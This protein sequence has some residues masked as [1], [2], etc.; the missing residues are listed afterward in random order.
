M[1]RVPTAFLAIVLVAVG[2]AGC[3]SPSRGDAIAR[4]EG[5]YSFWPPPPNDPRI[6]FLASFRLSSDVE[7]PRGVID[8]LVF[9]DDTEPLPIG[10]P[11]GVAMW[12]GRIY[13]CDIT[14]PAVV[15]LDLRERETRL[16]VARGVER[17]V[18]PTDIAIA[19]DGMK[20]VVDRRLGRVFV[21]DAQDRHVTTFG[22]D[23]L[24][25]T[26]I[27]VRGEELLVPDMATKQVLVMNRRDGE[28][29][30]HIGGPDAESGSLVCPLGVEPAPGGSLFVTD[31]IRGVAVRY[32]PEGNLELELGGI[33]DAPGHFTRPKHIA[34][35]RDGILYVVDAAFQNVQL[36]DG[37]GQVLMFFGGAGEFGG[38]MSLPAGVAIS[39]DDLDLFA[40]LVHPDFEAQRLVIVTNQFGRNKVS[41]YAL[42]RLREGATLDDMPMA[43][44]TQ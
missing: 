34:V 42:G 1:N 17:M 21:F 38:S 28:R 20:Y 8:R 19:D 3:A 41:V 11:Y 44:S 29:I 12:K 10:K 33:G 22:E 26:G 37:E 2:A 18:Q 15:I 39:E 35:D 7:A 14:N 43:P 5:P 9:G 40:D 30:G 32:G 4:H 23:G 16:M 36:F 25:P 31:A 13:V 24:E 6:Q 27:A